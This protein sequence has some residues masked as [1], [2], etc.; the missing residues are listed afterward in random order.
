MA[1]AGVRHSPAKGAS[2]AP[3]RLS[4]LRPLTLP[5]RGNGKPRR[6][7]AS[8]E[9]GRVLALYRHRIVSLVASTLLWI[10]A[11]GP[12]SNCHQKRFSDLL[13]RYSYPCGGLYFDPKK[14]AKKTVGIGI[15]WGKSM[16]RL[17]VGLAFVLS[18]G[19]FAFISSS[20]E[21]QQARNLAEFCV[22]W[23]GVCNRTCPSG[24]GNC[25]RDCA[26]RVAACRSSGC[27]HFNNPGP[28]CY[29]NARDRERT[30]AKYAPDPKRA[31]ERRQKA[32]ETSI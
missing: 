23:Q 12:G 14:F 8:R 25:S 27:F 11:P 15:I 29:N 22:V 17:I 31:M 24:A 3:E 10:D 32:R 7:F 28:R 13:D 19:V 18:V 2:Q 1:P 26:S 21:A 4:A 5:V 20:A 30:D 9:Q 6:I 16:S